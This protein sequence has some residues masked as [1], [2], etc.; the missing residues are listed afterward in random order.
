MMDLGMTLPTMVPGLDRAAVLDW[1]RAIDHGPFATLAAGERVTY[2]NQDLF[3]MLAAAAA[4]TERVTIMSTV[5]VL[6]AHPAVDI[7][8]R[9]ATLDVLSG[10]RFVLGVGVGGRDADYEALEAEPVRRY[11]RLDEQVATMQRVWAGEPPF[12]GADPVGPPPVQPGGPPLYAGVFGPKATA[13]AARWAQ[14]VCGFVF[15]PLGDDHGAAFAAIDDAWAAAGRTERPRRVTSF[16]Y[17]LGDDAP[18]RL[19]HYAQRYL[20]IFGPEVAAMLAASCSA[21]GDE[22]VV[23]ALDKVRAAGCDECI[24]VPTSS[25]LD[26]LDRLVALVS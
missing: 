12:P 10:G 8:K 5:V 6:P 4:V 14:G 23:A 2:H 25:D 16:W 21:A 3:T 9:A 13:R 24:L 7:A 11:A 20:G 22:A 15:D 1:C 17:A 19:A 26:E 18:E